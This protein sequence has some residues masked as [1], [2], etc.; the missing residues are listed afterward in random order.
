M[1]RSKRQETK[2]EQGVEVQSDI[3]LT[4][5]GN[6]LLQ[7]FYDTMSNI[8][9]RIWKFSDYQAEQ[10]LK[11]QHKELTSAVG[12]RKGMELPKGRF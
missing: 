3:M 11:K 2:Q 6:R 1:R 9:S 4:E 12:G 8:D 7:R 10:N 5:T